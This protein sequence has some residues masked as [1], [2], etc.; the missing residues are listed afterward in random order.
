MTWR[1]DVKK[2][3]ESKIINL[4]ELSDSQNHVNKKKNFLAPLQTEISESSL[5]TSWHDVMTSRNHK[6]EKLMAF[7]NSVT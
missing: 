1:H 6:H 2:S 5:V 4:F 7:L 3:H